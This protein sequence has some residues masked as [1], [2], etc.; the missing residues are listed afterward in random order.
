MMCV[1]ILQQDTNSDHSF[2]LQRSFIHL[3]EP[4]DPDQGRSGSGTLLVMREHMLDHRAA[5]KMRKTK[6]WT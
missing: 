3:Q 6:W 4:L 5:Q 2:S 1:Y